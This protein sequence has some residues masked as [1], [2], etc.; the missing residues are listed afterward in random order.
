L[1]ALFRARG[2]ER[3]NDAIVQTHVVGGCLCVRE[4]RDQR[5]RECDPCRERDRGSCPAACRSLH[6]TSVSGRGYGG[7]GVRRRPHSSSSVTS[8]PCGSHSPWSGSN[9]CS[10]LP[11]LTPTTSKRSTPSSV[12]IVSEARVARSSDVT[13]TAAIVCPRAS[14]FT[15]IQRMRP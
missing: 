3:K 1:R 14:S 13:G 9:A 8:Q 15:T 7:Q 12:S 6:S 11:T 2:G 10:V 4:R 5:P